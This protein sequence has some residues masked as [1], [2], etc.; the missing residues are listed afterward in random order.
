MDTAWV[1]P[2]AGVLVRP[3]TSADDAWVRATLLRN[4]SSTTVA[5]SGELVGAEDLPGFVA[6]VGGRR[7]GLAL[8]KVQGYELEIVAISTSR[9]R[10]GVG[11]ALFGACVDEARDRGCHRLWLVT[12]NNNLTAIAFYERLGMDLCAFRRDQVRVSRRL[13][14]SIPFRDALG[15]PVDHELEFEVILMSGASLDRRR[16]VSSPGG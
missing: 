14:P 3:R 8:V 5:R 9:R 13:K 11:R 6:L 1:Y 10:Q 15:V 12:T 4:W 2:G 7:V 16:P